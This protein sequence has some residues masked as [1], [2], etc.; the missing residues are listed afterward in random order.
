M[1]EVVPADPQSLKGVLIAVGFIAV[2]VFFWCA[3]N[4]KIAKEGWAKVAKLHPAARPIEGHR[5]RRCSGAFGASSY[6]NTIHAIV[7]PS[8]I[9]L[10][11]PWLFSYGHFR[12]C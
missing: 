8:G 10:Y 12:S 3:I 4:G 5:F 7:G 6:N 1:N 11:S 9:Y 2:F